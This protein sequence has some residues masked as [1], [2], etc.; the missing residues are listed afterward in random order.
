MSASC[1]DQAAIEHA[2]LYMCTCAR[3]GLSEETGL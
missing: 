1:Q 3:F 2:C